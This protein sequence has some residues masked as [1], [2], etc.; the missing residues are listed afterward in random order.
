MLTKHVFKAL[1]FFAALTSG[2]QTFAASPPWYYYWNL[3]VH[4][5]GID[6]CV[7]VLALEF[8][9]DGDTEHPIVIPVKVCQE[10]LAKNL[11]SFL[12]SSFSDRIVIEIR[13][14]DGGVVSEEPNHWSHVEMMEHFTNTFEGN[15][16]FKK[17]EP[18]L[19]GSAATFIPDVVQFFCDNISVPTGYCH[20]LVADAFGLV[21]KK[22][23]SQVSLFFTT[24]IKGK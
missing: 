24:G 8:P 21:L 11:A 3:V 7:D 22:K 17:I 6:P 10:S 9:P 23:A 15:P 20:F 18:S 4:T 14:P 5:V 12:V 16:L 2:W 1:F 19:F 13:G